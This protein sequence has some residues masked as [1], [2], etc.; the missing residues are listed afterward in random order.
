[1]SLSNRKGGHPMA[2][3]QIVKPV[4]AVAAVALLGFAGMSI[5][6][7]RL[8]ADSDESNSRV[9]I[10]FNIAPVKL[11]LHGL[12]PAKVGKGSFI[13]NAQGDC[14]GCHNNPR[15]G[16]EFAVGHDPYLGQPKMVNASAYL[17][18]GSPFGP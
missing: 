3:M 4:E 10:G 18:G 14:N 13:V 15:L 7:P 9:Q 12:N 1:M 8:R 2:L 11:N 6:S 5:I 16:G 17:A